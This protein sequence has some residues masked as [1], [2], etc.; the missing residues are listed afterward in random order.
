MTDNIQLECPGCGR[1][2]SIGQKECACGRPIVISTFNSIGTMSMLEVNKYAGAYRKALSMAPDNKELNA[3]A[4]FCFLKLKM[5]DAAIAAFD[6]A[7]VENFDNPDTFFY[8]AISRLRGK[9]A[10]L[11][12]RPDINK[13][14]ELVNSAIMI[15]PRGIY[16]FFLAYIKYDYF[17][18]K[19]LNT[20]PD[21]R[22]LSSTAKELGYSELDVTN[23][24]SLLNTECP[25]PIL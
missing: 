17:E 9:K 23:L 1:P 11:A 25:S 8:A 2:V 13:I 4:A 16:Y 22:S 24:F 7:I 19:Y 15:E 21:Y 20:D 10:F 12:T 14:E 6:K 5:Y 18:R 3:S